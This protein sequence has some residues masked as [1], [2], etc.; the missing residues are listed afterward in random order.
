MVESEKWET[1]TQAFLPAIVAI[2][3]LDGAHN[4]ILWVRDL[5]RADGRFGRHDLGS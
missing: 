4:L 2:G 1:N 3:R 5:S